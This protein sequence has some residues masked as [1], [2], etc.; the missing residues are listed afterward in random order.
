MDIETGNGQNTSIILKDICDNLNK[1]RL[2]VFLNYTWT[3]SKRVLNWIFEAQRVLIQKKYGKKDRA[4][5]NYQA[6]Q[7]KFEFRGHFEGQKGKKAKLK[8]IAKSFLAI[9]GKDTCHK[10]LKCEG[11]REDP[12]GSNAKDLC[13][14]QNFFS[15]FELL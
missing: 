9:F 2:K 13:K 1:N 12:A 3:V 7:V 14:F 4:P 8:R 10:E 11:S 5:S 15:N 6:D